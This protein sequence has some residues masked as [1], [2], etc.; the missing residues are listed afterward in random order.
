MKDQLA[1]LEKQLEVL[2]EGSLAR[3]LGAEISPSVVAGQLARAMEEVSKQDE[4]GNSFAPD[5]YALTLN[6]D[7]A[8]LLLD[9]APN[10]HSVLAKGLLEAVRSVGYIIQRQP[11]ITIAADPTLK[12]WEVRV[13]AW[14]SG[15]PL[16]FTHPM[17]RDAVLR[18][19]AL[20]DGAF[21]IV[22][23]RGH[24]ALDRPVVNIGRRLDNQLILDNP[25]VSRT[26][27]QL[28]V[29]DGRFVLFDLGSTIGTK[30]NGRAVRQHVLRQGD[31]I[32]IAEIRLVYG[33]DPAGPPDS[34]EAYTPPFPPRPAGDQKTR[35]EIDPDRDL[36]DLLRE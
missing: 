10:I 22:D 20:P 34:T 30:V 6:P 3:L 16:E 27:A 19:G 8:N 31:V 5:Q 4:Q 1:R 33:E 7:D 2:V 11:N 23:G 18:S 32:S 26:H 28:R 24:Y 36:G 15:N 17:Q 35:S 21:L 12:R 9:S 14:H 13:V 25:H 29:R